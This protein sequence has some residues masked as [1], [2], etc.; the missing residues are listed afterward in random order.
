MPDK[1]MTDEEAAQESKKR[2]GGRGIAY[3][4]KNNY[5]LVGTDHDG[6]AKQEATGISSVSWEDA[7]RDA[8]TRQ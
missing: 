1:P 2:W 7:F 5:F 6:G 3:K 8:Q 4:G